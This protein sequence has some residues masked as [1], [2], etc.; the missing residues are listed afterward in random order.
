MNQKTNFD[1][2]IV[3]AGSAGCI[4]ADRLS[5]SGKYSVLVLEAGKKDKSFWFKI[6]VGF[7][8]TYYHPVYNYM[9]YSTPQKEMDGREIYA[10]R[11]KV[12]GGS[13]A[14]NAMIYVRGNKK[15]FDD[16]A[17]AG[18]PGWSYNDVL[19]YFKKLESRPNGNSV[20]RG[21]A[22]KIG[23]TPM[24]E[25]AHEIC[26]DFLNA[27]DELGLPK[28]EDFNGEQFEGAGIY[29]VNVANGQR[30]SSGVAY[31][32]PAL[33][34]TNVT[35][36]SEACVERIHFEK[37][38][39]IGVT[40]T[41][42]GAEQIFVAD[43]EVILA[44]GAVDSPKLLQ[45]SGIGDRNLLEKHQIL[46]NKH[47]PA[48]GENLQDHHCV[49]YY[50]KAN[51]K[52][53]NDKFRS[54]LGQAIAGMQYVLTR[55]GPLSLSVNQSGGF[56]KSD[57]NESE[58]NIQLYFNPMS[59]RIPPN[60]NA[61][62]EPEPYSGFL[63]AFNS[64][65]PTSL[66]SV[67]IQSNDPAAKPVIDPNYLSTEKDIKE[68]IA[69]SKLIRKVMGSNTLQAITV[70]EESPG[71]QCQSEEQMLD[72]YRKNSGS[73]YHLCG[74]CKM[75]PD[76]QDSVVDARLR[77]HGIE[78]LRVVDASIF[79]NITSGNINAPV[80]MVAEKAAEIILQ[81]Y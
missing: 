42:N 18:N 22:G 61:K 25:G 8:K 33:K 12:V 35:L 48:V 65:R 73:I 4:L 16:W 74:T 59:Y 47:L 14:I 2:I 78:N 10:P 43:K 71:T 75:G 44:A 36:I 69:G 39:A 55:K 24:H 63:L 53:L 72:Y 3:G 6:P 29:E 7:A 51:K 77:V 9:Y 57:D 54:L 15:D 40:A 37:N 81:E 62:L 52:T 45:L 58:P 49:S 67:K 17:E 79:P 70:S 38:R 80:M 13:G 21:T 56:F 76:E 20:Y 66:G 41:I 34:R 26:H 46:V 5:E 30:A 11:G 28:T 50:Y 27:C 60:P 23:I 32:K 19:P 64:C 31:L 1:F 68:A